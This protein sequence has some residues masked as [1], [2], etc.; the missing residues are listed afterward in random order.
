MNQRGSLALEGAIC[1][2]LSVAALLL[3]FRISASVLQSQQKNHA[4][5]YEERF[6]KRGRSHLPALPF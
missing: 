1:L 5:F 4:S 6:K 2:F 3:S